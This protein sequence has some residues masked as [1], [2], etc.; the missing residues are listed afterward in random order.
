[1]RKKLAACKTLASRAEFLEAAPPIE[2]VVAAVSI[3]AA[4][5]CFMSTAL[6]VGGVAALALVPVAVVLTVY[7][8]RQ[9]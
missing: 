8:L 6:R 2:E 4:L 3:C 9:G 7:L 5:E 1:M